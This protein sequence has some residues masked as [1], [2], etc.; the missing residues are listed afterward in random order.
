MLSW[1]VPPGTPPSA[2]VARATAVA[3][4]RGGGGTTLGTPTVGAEDEAS[5]AAVPP[6]IPP[7]AVEQ[8]RSI[9]SYPSR[10][11]CGLPPADLPRRLVAW[12]DVRCG[13]FRSAS[14]AVE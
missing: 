14:R 10:S 3:G 5:N 9:M 7:E 4:K 1:G 6:D 12:N 13:K 11:P 2:S 8:P